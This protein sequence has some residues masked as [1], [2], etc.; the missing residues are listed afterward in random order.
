MSLG[1]SAT[2]TRIWVP[3]FLTETGLRTEVLCQK[4]NKSET[5]YNNKKVG[6]TA[7]PEGR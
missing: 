4:I 5:D 6:R 7:L 3:V 2:N 1:L